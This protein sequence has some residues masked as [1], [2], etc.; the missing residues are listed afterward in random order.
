MNRPLRRSPQQIDVP[1]LAFD[2]MIRARSVNSADDLDAV[3][4]KA[5]GELG[6]EVFVGVNAVDA[7]G[8][9]NV[10]I[11]FGQTHSAWESHY[12]EQGY[13]RHDALIQE[14]LA[15]SDA[16]FWSDVQKRRRIGPDETR[17]LNEA[18][19]YGLKNGFMAPLHNI[20]GSISAVL[21]MGRDV[22][23][24]DP[25]LHAAS[26]MLSVFYASAAQRLRRDAREDS[27]RLELAHH[28]SGRQIECLKWASAGKSSHD[29]S[30]ILGISNRTVDEHLAVACRKLGVRTRVQAVAEALSYGVLKG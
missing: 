20:D 14:M 8:K 1:R 22:E 24:D 18:G 21:L 10:E 28:L 25:Y 19:E 15:S 23:A 9:P 12:R 13:F 29:I 16:V 11:L 4:G 2:A 6:Y 17:V 5:F 7:R 26:W 30:T 3:L 27:L